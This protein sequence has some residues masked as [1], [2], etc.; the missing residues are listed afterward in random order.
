MR[1]DKNTASVLDKRTIRGACYPYELHMKKGGIP[2]R[3]DGERNPFY[4]EKER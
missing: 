3:I 1:L 4:H 2:E